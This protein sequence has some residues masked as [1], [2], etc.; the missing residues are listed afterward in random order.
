M[1]SSGK[2]A[3]STKNPRPQVNVITT[4]SEKALR[5]LPL[6]DYND[7]VDEHEEKGDQEAE[8]EEEVEWNN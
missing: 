6:P 3:A 5:D 8:R 4:R 1:P 2:L 7:V